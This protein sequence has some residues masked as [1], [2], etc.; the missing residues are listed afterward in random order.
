MA[1]QEKF[2]IFDQGINERVSKDSKYSVNCVAPQYLPRDEK[3]GIWSLVDDRKY[4]SLVSEI[5]RSN[6][7]DEEKKFFLLAATRFLVFNYAKIADYYANSDKQVQEIM[8]KL[9]LVI[10]D[11]ED[12]IANGFVKLNKEVE[13]IAKTSKEYADRLQKYSQ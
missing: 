1:F 5:E 12:A 3:P 7:P 10:I 13:D 11:I 4:T 9:A 2:D 8:E 6:L